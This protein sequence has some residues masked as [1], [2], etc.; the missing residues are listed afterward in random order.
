MTSEATEGPPAMEWPHP[1]ALANT[2]IEVLI[3]ELE[4]EGVLCIVLYVY[5][6]LPASFCREKKTHTFVYLYH[7]DESQL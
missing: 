2:N 3:N 6:V 7:D 1:P 5:T 4:N